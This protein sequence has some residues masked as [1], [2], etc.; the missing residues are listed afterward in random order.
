MG[1]AQT[2][3][4]VARIIAP[5]AGTSAFQRIGVDAPFLLGGVTM[6]GVALLSWRFVRPP[7]PAAA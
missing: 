3:A 2:F 6:L 4:G 5:I 1:V 7:V